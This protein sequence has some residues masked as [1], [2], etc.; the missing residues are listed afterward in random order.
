LDGDEMS[1]DRPL[2]LGSAAAAHRIA[3]ARPVAAAAWISRGT[4]T[5]QDTPPR[6]ALHCTIDWRPVRFRRRDDSFTAG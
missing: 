5:Y 4:A 2:G 3:G 1:T 6:H